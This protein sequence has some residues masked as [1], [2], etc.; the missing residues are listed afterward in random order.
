MSCWLPGAIQ[1]AN[2]LDLAGCWMAPHTTVLVLSLPRGQRDESRRTPNATADD[3]DHASLVRVKPK[4]LDAA[5]VVRVPGT[6]AVRDGR[7]ILEDGRVL[8]VR[9][10]G[11]CTGYRSVFDWIEVDVL[12]QEGRPMHERGTT[13]EP[14]LYFSPRALRHV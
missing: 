3:Q 8:D 1:A 14:G 6:V 10:V 5:G 9:N 12:D 2:R 4:D 11:W 13:A 7:P